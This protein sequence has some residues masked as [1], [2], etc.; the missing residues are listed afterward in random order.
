[1]NLQQRLYVL[2]EEPSKSRFGIILTIFIYSLIIINILD[3]MLYSVTE[4]RAKY[5]YILESINTTIMPIFIT[6]YIIRLY[7]SGAKKGF[8]GVKG[9]LKYAVTPYAII[10]LLSILPYILTNTGFNSS[11]I[12]SLRLLRIFRIKKYAIFI[13]LMKNIFHNIKEEFLV[14]LIFTLIMIVLLSFIIFEIE[15]KAQ[16][17]VFKNIFETMWWAVATLTTVGY[18]DMYPIT[19]SGKLITAIITI[20]GI[21]FVAI[22][23]GI[24]ASEFTSAITKAKNSNEKCFKCGSSDIRSHQNPTLSIDDR[25]KEFK[26]LYTCKNCN[27]SWLEDNKGH[28]KAP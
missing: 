8:E 6:E 19:A 26:T 15:H 18:G 16:P 13:R 27:F 7:A 22:P 2:L 25:T 21:G 28:K 3:L 10:D 1:M 4:I 23:G 20:L 17:N 12:R 14:L 5:G 9:K 11:F 24:F